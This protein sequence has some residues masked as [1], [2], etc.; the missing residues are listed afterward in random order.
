MLDQAL[1]R[2]NIACGVIAQGLRE[3][4]SI[5]DNKIKFAY[6][7]LPEWL[8]AE[9]TLTKDSTD[10]LEFNNGSSIYV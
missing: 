2:S 4:K 7:N 9:R 10:T 8:R 1:F 5:F 6:D 3:A